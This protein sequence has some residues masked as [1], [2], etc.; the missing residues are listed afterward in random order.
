MSLLN[1]EDLNNRREN[2]RLEAKAARGGIPGSI[3]ES[4]SA[5]ANTAGGTVLLGV[6]ERDDGSLEAVGLDD[7]SKMLDDF[8]NAALS[9]DKL[10]ARFMSDDN[11]RIEEVDGKEIIVIDVPWVNRHDRPVF[12]DKDILDRTFRRTHTG[13]HRCSREEVQSMIRDA[14]VASQDSEIIDRCSMDD[15]DYD[16]VRRFRNGFNQG[17]EDHAWKDYDEVEFLRAL[18]AADILPDGSVHPTGAGLLMFGYDRSITKGFPH[19][20]LDYREETDPSNRWVDR[21]TSQPGDWSGNIYDFYYRVYNKLK[22]AL[23][24]PFKL[25][26]DMHRVDETP[27]HKALREAIANCLTNANYYDRRGIVCLWRE[28]AIIIENPGDFRMPLS[29]AMKPGKSDPRNETMLKIFGFVNVGERAGSGITTIFDGWKEAGYAEPFYDVEYGPD[30][31]ILTLPLIPRRDNQQPSTQDAESGDF[32]SH[33]SGSSIP[34]DVFARLS[35]NEKAAVK[36][37]SRTGRVTTSALADDAEISTRAASSLLKRLEKNG[38]LEWNGKSSNDPH[39]YYT[40]AS[41]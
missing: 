21:F 35:A 12:L 28:D 19:Y 5:F 41:E 9:K 31:T 27:A 40:L 22:H 4:I 20:F 39:Q 11:A 37:A 29:E 1:L 33:S 36:I 24:T 6:K 23:K 34:L 30:R 15:L 2:N 17:R 25:D 26:E 7:A 14:S 38:I 3:W 10:S 32:L 13:D 16:T 8:W 18:G